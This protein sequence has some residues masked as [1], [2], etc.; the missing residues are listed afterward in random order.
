MVKIKFFLHFGNYVLIVH[1]N[2]SRRDSSIV[3]VL[4]DSWR[5]LKCTSGKASHSRVYTLPLHCSPRSW[6]SCIIQMI[7][8]LALCGNACGLTGYGPFG[9]RT[10]PPGPL[11]SSWFS[12]HKID[13]HIFHWLPS[14]SSGLGER[15]LYSSYK[16]CGKRLCRSAIPYIQNDN[17]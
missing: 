17:Q 13:K 11:S 7:R 8:V 14:L 1:L 6:L 5:S 10:M 15:R 2:E 16:C 3:D 4:P 9:S 12:I